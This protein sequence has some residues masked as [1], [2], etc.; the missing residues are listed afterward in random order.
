MKNNDIIQK[1]KIVDL[2]NILLLVKIRGNLH[3]AKDYATEEI[4]LLWLYSM[5]S[6]FLLYV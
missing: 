2:L 3:K 5:L 4:V 6:G 1:Y